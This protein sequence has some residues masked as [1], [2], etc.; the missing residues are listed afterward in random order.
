M[1]EDIIIAEQQWAK[2]F[3]ELDITTIENL[4][5]DDYV[6]I[7]QNGQTETKQQVLE[8]LKSQQRQWESASS[9]PY[10][11]RLYGDVAVVIGHWKSKGKNQDK[12]FDYTARYLAVWVKSPKGWR[13]VADQ[14]TPIK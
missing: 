11:I 8:S 9:D 14:S 7:Q 10:D 3:L 12:E 13:I 5:A 1:L 2:A 4:M 6:L